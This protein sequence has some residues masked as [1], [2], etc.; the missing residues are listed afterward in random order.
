MIRYARP[1]RR[2]RH[3]PGRTPSGSSEETRCRYQAWSGLPRPAARGTTRPV[4]HFRPRRV[5][6]RA[7][8]TCET[9]SA[10]TQKL[11]VPIGAG[12]PAMIARRGSNAANIF[13]GLTD[14][15]ADQ[16]AFDRASERFLPLSA[17]HYDAWQDSKFEY[18]AA[19][20]RRGVEAQP[21][22]PY[23]RSDLRDVWADLLMEA[24]GEVELARSSD[25]MAGL[26]ANVLRE[27]AA[28]LRLLKTQGSAAARS[29]SSTPRP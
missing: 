11:W 23:S 5:L 17:R 25:A 29:A 6:G 13:L 8:G 18:E 26:R 22:K 7:A 28:T 19:A 20:L 3:E 16:V 15:E 1:K 10:G 2:L 21:F 27:I 12:V 9:V 4:L 14:E 24:M